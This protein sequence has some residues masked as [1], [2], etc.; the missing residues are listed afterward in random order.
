MIRFNI[1]GE[2]LDLPA[3]FSLQFKKKNILFAFDSAECERSASFDIPATPKNDKIFNLSK[4][5]ATP[6]ESMRRRFNAQ[7]QDG[8]VVKDGYLYIDAYSGGKY[9]AIFI[10][11]ELLGLKQI[12]DLGNI[13]ESPIFANYNDTVKA[14]TGYSGGKTPAAAANTLWENV[15]YH[16]TELATHPSISVAKLLHSMGIYDRDNMI[17]AL[18]L[19]WIP[20]KLNPIQEEYVNYAVSIKNKT[21]GGYVPVGAPAHN[22]SSITLEGISG[23][24]FIEDAFISGGDRVMVGYIENGTTYQGYVTQRLTKYRTL[25]YFPGSTPR[26]CFI[27]YFD[28]QTSLSQRYLNLSDFHFLGNWSFDE[29]GNETG[30]PLSGRDVSIPAGTYFCVIRKSWWVN[31]QGWKILTPTFDIPYTS[32]LFDEWG[33]NP[34]AVWRLKDNLPNCTAVDLLKIC[35]A[36]AGGILTYENDQVVIEWITILDGAITDISGKVISTSDV[37]RKFADYAQI[38]GIVYAYDDNQYDYEADAVFYYI[39]NDNLDAQKV[40]LEMKAGNGTVYE[41]KPNGAR[42][43]NVRGEQSVDILGCWDTRENIY[44]CQTALSKFDDLQNLCDASTSVTVKARLSLLEYEQIQPRT[45]IYYD[46]VLYVW[47]EAQYG[48]D[49][50]T[51]KLSKISA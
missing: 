46:G 33:N 43:L 32:M 5:I 45:R 35:A 15:N 4:W 1:G 49:V 38:N 12:R 11:G 25:I 41:T 51:L 30:T 2:Y 16:H 6:G 10:T 24:Y 26:D 31:N 36:I 19:R 8:L 27:G 37:N 34:P 44:L 28:P 3:N 20:K 22:V 42:L 18:Q 29:N 50:V 13:N 48:K 14:L 23:E 17:D 9:K 39:D 7:M 40:I 21:D 47:T